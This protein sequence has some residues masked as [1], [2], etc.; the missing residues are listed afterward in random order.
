MCFISQ[1]CQVYSP[2][3]AL[4]KLIDIFAIYYPHYKEKL[5]SNLTQTS[6]YTANSFYFGY[7]LSNLENLSITSLFVYDGGACLTKLGIL[8]KK[9]EP[10]KTFLHNSYTN[11]F[12][13]LLLSITLKNLLTDIYMLSNSK[14][15]IIYG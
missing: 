5:V 15:T 13:F 8:I 1:D 10:S 11:E 6:I 3:L 2:T 9:G 12:L 4:Y 14:Y 7:S